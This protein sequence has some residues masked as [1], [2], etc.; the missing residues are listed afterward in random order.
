MSNDEVDNEIGLLF[1]RSMTELSR[2][3]ASLYIERLQTR[4]LRD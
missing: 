1:G 2:R 3:D 4:M